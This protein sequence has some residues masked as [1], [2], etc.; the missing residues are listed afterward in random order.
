M[1]SHQATE[2]LSTPLNAPLRRHPTLTPEAARAMFEDTSPAALE[3]HGNTDRYGE[4]RV[5]QRQERVALL[6]QLRD[7]SAPV[8]LSAPGGATVATTLWSLDAATDRLHFAVEPNHPQL[9]RLLDA[10]EATAVSYLDSVKLQFDLASP[11]LV[12]GIGTASLQCRFPLELY[13]FQRRGA[14]RVRTVQRHSPNAAFRHPSIPDMKVELPVIDVSVG[15]CSLWLPQ[16]VPALQ[17]GTR[18]VEVAIWL[19]PQTQFSASMNLQHVGDYFPGDKGVRL[20]CGWQS[21]DSG[22][23]R[24]LQRWIDQSQ[25]R[26]R[27]VLTD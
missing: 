16:D 5:T 23:A 7:G 10:G 22:A 25:K 26:H 14:Y 9:N 1:L 6:R 2:L 21:L 17:A 12:R 19:D 11:L 18:L 8:I 15:G 24:T 4:F 20:G 3:A 13:R 27:L